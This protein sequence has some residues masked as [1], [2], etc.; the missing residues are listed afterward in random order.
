MKA[1][2]LLYSGITLLI[3]GITIK[4][5]TGLTLLPGFV[6]IAG[7]LLKV[8]YIVNQTRRGEYKPGIEIVFLCT[9]LILFIFGIYFCPGSGSV[10]R[11]FFIVPGIVL[12][13]LFVVQFIR[14][15]IA[16]KNK[17]GLKANW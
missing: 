8:S 1:K 10:N 16:A 2:L 12:K 17:D 3:F 14:K 5:T 13:V 4:K 15:S 9:G 6:I 11:A 7:V